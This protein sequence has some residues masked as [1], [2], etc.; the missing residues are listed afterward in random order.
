MRWRQSPGAWRLSQWLSGDAGAYRLGPPAVRRIPAAVASGDF[1]LVLSMNWYLGAAWWAAKAAR[2]LGLPHLASPLLHISSPWADRDAIRALI[3]EADGLIVN[4]EAE[5]EFVA[6]RGARRAWSAGVGVEA[7]PTDPDGAAQFR[8]RHG[9]DD[10]PVVAFVGRQDAGKGVPT[11][12]AAME[13]VRQRYPRA[14]LM[15]AGRRRHRSAEVE[16]IIASLPPDVRGKLLL[17]DDFSDD[18]LPAILGAADLL[19]LPSREESF[20]IA[21]LEA[22]LAERPVIGADIPA[23]RQVVRDGVDGLLAAPGDSADLAARILWLL[24]HR[25]EATRFGQRGR[26]RVLTEFSWDRVTDTWESACETVLTERR[27]PGRRH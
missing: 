17:Q 11:L 19:A 22:W 2:R 10:R 26:Q 9:L 21:F 12:M 5:R 6:A 15:L 13:L 7:T 24:D 3:R 16:A 4:T 14:V 18:E 1:E 8:V 27:E 25:E 23:I 20:G